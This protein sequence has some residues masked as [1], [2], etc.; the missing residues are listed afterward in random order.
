MILQSKEI[1]HECAV[2][3]VPKTIDNE[4]RLQLA[5]ELG[6]KRGPDVAL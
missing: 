3:G 5:D 2:V 4:T 6:K 1:D